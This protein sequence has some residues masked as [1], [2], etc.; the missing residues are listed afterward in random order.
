MSQPFLVSVRSR[1][2]KARIFLRSPLYTDVNSLTARGNDPICI[3]YLPWLQNATITN[4]SN[5]KQVKNW[6][7]ESGIK[8]IFLVIVLLPEHGGPQGISIADD[9]TIGD[10]GFGPIDLKAKTGECGVMLNSAPSIR[11]KGLAVEA[12]DINFAYGFDHLGLETIDFGTDNNNL[13]MRRL[14]ERK[15]G[16]SGT[17]NEEKG[18]W[19][20]VVTKEWWAERSKA[21]GEDRVVVD[22]EEIPFDAGELTETETKAT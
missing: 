20:F 10:S 18:S 5:M 11:G 8:G 21:A 22:A 4:E 15:F 1:S 7:A 12:L 6:R 9:A 14:L 17:F 2:P 13:P 19:R 3:Q 16:L